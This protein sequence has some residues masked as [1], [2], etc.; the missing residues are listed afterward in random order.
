MMASLGIKNYGSS[1][2]TKATVVVQQS[3]SI[4]PSKI[5][6][7]SLGHGE[8]EASQPAPLPPGSA[9]STHVDFMDMVNDSFVEGSRESSTPVRVDNLFSAHGPARQF[10]SARQQPLK[11]HEQTRQCHYG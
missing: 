1:D 8:V 10:P 11:G 5:G 2:L 3:R 6:G 7:A 4:D 9:L